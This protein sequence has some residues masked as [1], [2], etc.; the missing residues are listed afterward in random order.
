[1]CQISKWLKFQGPFYHLEEILSR[2]LD[3]EL[4]TFL[5][6]KGAV[7]LS[8][9]QSYRFSYCVT[10]IKRRY[11]ITANSICGAGKGEEIKTLGR[12][13]FVDDDWWSGGSKLFCNWIQPDYVVGFRGILTL[14]GWGVIWERPISCVQMQAQVFTD[15]PSQPWNSFGVTGIWGEQAGP[16]ILGKLIEAH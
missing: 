1:M 3:R 14:F 15:M 9:L 12:S 13:V 10:D 5:T 11:S 4:K 7:M 16:G 8:V 6:L 2:P